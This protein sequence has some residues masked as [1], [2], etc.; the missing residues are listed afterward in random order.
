MKKRTFLFLSLVLFFTSIIVGITNS[1]SQEVKN[2]E[3]LNKTVQEQQVD[4]DKK[5]QDLSEDIPIDNVSIK[6]GTDN[7]QANIIFNGDD[8]F[9]GGEGFTI[10]NSISVSGNTTTLPEGAYTSIKIRKDQ[11]VKPLESSIDTSAE[12]IMSAEVIDDP[13]SDYYELRTYYKALPGGGNWATPITL[14]LLPRQTINES[15]NPIEQ[16]VFDNQGNEILTEPN[17]I[18][19]IGVAKIEVPRDVSTF[20]ITNIES[21]NY[22]DNYELNENTVFDFYPTSMN[23]RVLDGDNDP[24]LRRVFAEIPSETSVKEGTGWIQVGDTNKYYK[25]VSRD[26]IKNNY[27]T[28]LT[29]SLDLKGIDMSNHDILDNDPLEKKVKFTMQPVV[30]G[31][32]QDDID[33]VNWE[34]NRTFTI[35]KIDSDG[36]IGLRT[37]RYATSI[38]KDSY[39]KINSTNS[40]INPYTNIVS[41]P[42]VTANLMDQRIRYSHQNIT[43]YS[44]INTTGDL[45]NLELTIK[46]STITLSKYTSPSELRI[47]LLQG[48]DVTQTSLM[49]DKLDGTKAYGVKEDGSLVEIATIAKDKIYQYAY[50][51][52]SF[53]GEGWIDIPNG[54][55]YK[56]IKFVYPNNGVK[57]EGQE[58]INALYKSIFTEVIGDLKESLVD[59]LIT[60]LESHNPPSLLSPYTSERVYTDTSFKFVKNEGDEP[61]EQTREVS[62]ISLEYFRLQYDSITR[63]QSINVENSSYYT[64]NT[65]KT[66]VAYK[67]NLYG[68]YKPAQ[69]PENLNIYYL[70]PDG[71]ELIED[72]DMFESITIEPGYKAGYNL[73][74]AKPKNH[75]IP[76]FADT[77]DAV[78][79]YSENRLELDFKVTERLDIGSYKVYSFLSIDNNKLDSIDDKQYGIIQF[80][81][82]DEVWE[83]VFD[84]SNDQIIN[85]PLDKNK[86]TDFESDT[87]YIYPPKQLFVKKDVKLASDTE[88]NFASSIGNKGKL[89]TKIDYRWTIQNNSLQTIDKLTLIDILP[90]KGDKSI[91]KN[92]DGIYTNRGSEFKT[93]LL[94]VSQD[95]DKFTLYYSTDEVNENTHENY[96]AD[97]IKADDF[98]GNVANVTMIKAILKEGKKIEKQEEYHIFT[99]NKIEDKSSIKDGEKAYN[100]VAFSIN[101]P[102]E[103]TSETVFNEALKT[104]VEVNYPKNNVKLI[105]V[106]SKVS[107]RLL[108]GAKFDLYLK[109][110]TDDQDELVKQDMVT[111]QNGEIVLQN[112]IIG[113]NYYLKETEAPLNYDILQEKIEFKVKEGLN[114]LTVKNTF[115]PEKITIKARK[116]WKDMDGKEIKNPPAMI[117]VQLY[118]KIIDN[119]QSQ[120]LAVGDP[121]ELNVA[122]GFTYNWVDLPKVDIYNNLISYSVKELEDSIPEG[123]QSGQQTGSGSV[124]DPF[125]LTN[126][127]KSNTRT[128]TAQKLWEN[129]P[130][131]NQLEVQFQLYKN[132][133]KEGQPVTLKGSNDLSD[134]FKYTW[135]NLPKIGP[136]GQEIVYTVQEVKVTNGYTVSNTKGSGTP[137]DPFTVTNT[138]NP[139]KITIKARKEWVN[140]DPSLAPA[141]KFQLYKNGEKYGDPVE[142]NKENGFTYNWEELDKQDNES[143]DIT[144][145]VKELDIPNGYKSSGESSGSGSIEDPF[146]I[147]NTYEPGKRD[148]VIKK[149][150]IGVDPTMA[151]AV[152]VELFSNGVKVDTEEAIIL[153]QDNDFT[154]TLKDMPKYGQDGKEI[155]YVLNE[156]DVDEVYTVS[157]TEGS[158]TIKDPFVITNTY[159]PEKSNLYVEKRW[160]GISSSKAPII[161]VQLYKDGV[162]QGEEVELNK[163]NNYKHVWLMMP[164]VGFN[165][166][167]IEYTVKEVSVPSGYK[168]INTS[169]TGSEDDPF[170]LVNKKNDVVTDPTDS[171]NMDKEKDKKTK[172]QV[173]NEFKK[174]LKSKN[175]STGVKGY[176]FVIV[177]LILGTISLYILNKKNKWK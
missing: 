124:S 151:P 155:V 133:V 146:V 45:E 138:Y 58:Q 86:F 121:V 35:R 21:D 163:D 104:E 2:E 54:E 89:G 82:P 67:H 131:N 125:L 48:L 158:G 36:T 174:I 128:V 136:N 177:I 60:K 74:I 150:W 148:I 91:V 59:E 22:D 1:F 16:R 162:A 97:W 93:E 53:N 145:T 49:K 20:Q 29:I 7:V 112:L 157:N 156:V 114:E 25:D 116:L 32:V 161:K 10:Y 175:P 44:P 70:V 171:E 126:I 154:Y 51:S 11:Y 105:K 147:T 90:Y 31:Q 139:D 153:N 61:V 160:T 6:Q 40:V 107:S 73:I 42:Y 9:I 50:S 24:R 88:E 56:A 39:E 18:I 152:E 57:L 170:I 111:N 87:F 132:G 43:K 94:G 165:G 46:S 14:T 28:A 81:I 110:E 3:D 5:T 115:S 127:Y 66:T 75:K 101:A 84:E 71:L 106:D 134:N 27:K 109:G 122:N 37:T 92:Q 123:Y 17:K 95:S 96:N 19:A 159:E 166:E 12:I 68:N 65:L 120:V 143:N 13:A 69:I 135:E 168:L 79:T 140:T 102:D 144:Y 80:D 4:I 98:N 33:L 8:T 34:V 129:A 141:V 176:G 72:N 78:S 142:L 15:E 113:K 38:K 108:Q 63:S 99:Q 117:K 30:D 100:S 47:I 103:A 62:D 172:Y 76:D 149:V 137:E 173:Y 119:N 164:M 41:V 55:N 83:N 77:Q 167:K 118:K 26:D 85:T 23:D 130:E 52:E 169:G 64:N